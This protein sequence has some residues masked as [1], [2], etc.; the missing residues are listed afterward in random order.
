MHINAN[1]QLNFVIGSP[2]VQSKSPD[3]HQHMYE[4]LNINAVLVAID[5]P[6]LPDFVQSMKTLN[7]H[8]CAVTLPFKS[9]ILD[10]VDSCSDEVTALGAANTLIHHE[11]KIHA[12]NTDVDGIRSGLKSV[13]L[14]GKKVLIIG[15]GGA[16][17]AAGYALKDTQAN[18][19]WMNRTEDKVLPLIE[20]FG[21]IY[22]PQDQ[23]SEHDIDVII[24]TTSVGMYPNV[25]ETP[26]PEYSFNPKQTVF[27]LIYN[28]VNTRLL[29]EARLAGSSVISGKR[30]FVEQAIRQVELCYHLTISEEHRR[31]LHTD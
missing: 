14:R 16:A 20:L 26:L 23:I 12:Y 22:I 5:N 21:G 30:L 18:L 24:N 19:L 10:Y 6:K 1:T 2:V 8:M 13:N 15:A 28:P 17:R 29:E 11:G 27:D 25:D 9:S 3:I 31:E 4:L 7:A